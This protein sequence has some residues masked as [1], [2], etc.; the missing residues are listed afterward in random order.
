MPGFKLKS[1]TGL[2]ISGGTPTYLRGL[3]E[4]AKTCINHRYLQ[5][6]V[7]PGVF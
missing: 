5:I 2:Q 7:Q 4:P 3:H 1:V 6:I